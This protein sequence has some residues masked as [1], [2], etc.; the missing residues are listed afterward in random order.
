[1]PELNTSNKSNIGINGIAF[2]KT[3]FSSATNF[4]TKS[5]TIKKNIKR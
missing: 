5:I 2:P 3:K 1:M 4:D